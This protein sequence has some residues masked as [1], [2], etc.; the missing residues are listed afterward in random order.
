MGII[1]TENNLT[2]IFV[3]IVIPMYN[4]EQYI[5]ACLNTCINQTH[6]AIEVLVVDDGSTDQSLDIVK[7]YQ[8]KDE[9]IHVVSQ[10]N[11]GLVE[12]RKV[13]VKNALYD[14]I[15]FL[16]AD[17]TLENDAISLLIRQYIKTGADLVLANFLVETEKKKLIFEPYN[18]YQYGLTAEGVLKS[19]LIKDAA[20]TIWGKLIKKDVFLQTNT[21]SDITIGEDVVTLFQILLNKSLKI[22]YIDDYIYHYIQ[23]P[24]S[25]VNKKSKIIVD[26]RLKLLEWIDNY[27]CINLKSTCQYERY[28]YFFILN[29]YFSLLKDGA[30]YADIECIIKQVKPELSSYYSQIVKRMGLI[31]WGLIYMS[32]N[33]F[34]LFLIM[35]KGYLFIR[36]LKYG[37]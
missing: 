33:F 34:S 37:I 36:K 2:D 23:R 24:S 3:S 26:K 29:E 28:Y 17:D 10:S 18:T 13:G 27:Y 30:K 12:T 8:C 16:D 11:K 14:L 21:P 31:R 6:S 15:V 22:S 20:P 32:M 5:S 19:V 1:S 4:S 7:K 35:R 25:M 9:R